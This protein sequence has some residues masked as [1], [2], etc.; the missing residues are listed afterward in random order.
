M[1][2]SEIIIAKLISYLPKVFAAVV[3]T[4][5][6]LALSGDIDTKGR[7]QITW[8]VVLKFTFAVTLSLY[9]G[10]AT[11]E[12]FHLQQFS[13]ATHGFIMLCFAVFGMVI[14]GVVYQSLALLRGKSL[15]DI[16]AEVGGAIKAIFRSNK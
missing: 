5:F 4:V 10:T 3:G 13:P 11:I 7:L 12:L 9:G 14:I 2:S 1:N 15:V 16:G 8:G 6:A